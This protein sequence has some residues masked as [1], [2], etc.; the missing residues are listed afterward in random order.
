MPDLKQV[1]QA[2]R[3]ITGRWDER[4]WYSDGHRT[5]LRFYCDFFGTV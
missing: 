1:K 3:W 2:K 4:W 5:C